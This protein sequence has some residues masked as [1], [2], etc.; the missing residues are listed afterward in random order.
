MEIVSAR[1]FQQRK[2]AENR[3]I[4]VI[5]RFNLNN[6]NRRL[7]AGVIAGPFA[8]WALR[9]HIVQADFAFNCDFSVGRERQSCKRTLD[10]A[11][12]TTLHPIIAKGCQVKDAKLAYVNGNGGIMSE[13][14]SL[15]LERRS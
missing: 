5:N 14:A 3:I 6:R 7:I 8:E 11:Q 15:V 13:Q 9:L 10:Y 2:P 1:R 4:A 12:V